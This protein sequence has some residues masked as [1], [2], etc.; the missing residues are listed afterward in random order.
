MNRY[1]LLLALLSAQAQ[2]LP[3]AQELAKRQAQFAPVEIGADIS[4][5]SDGDR[6][7]LAS[8]IKAA[9]VMD[10]LFLKQVW[11]AAPEWLLRLSADESMLG[12]ARLRYFL[13]QKGPWDRQDHNAAFIPDT[14]PKPAQANFYPTDATKEEVEAWIASLPEVEKAK[15]VG[16]FT[17]IRRSGPKFQTIPYAVEYQNDLLRAAAHLKD[18]AASTTNA[19]LKTFLN[20][21]A[22]AFL[23]DD[24]YDSDVAWMELDSPLE[25]TIGPYETYEDG[26]FSYKAAFEAFITL[27]DDA[28]TD[29]LKKFGAE[30]QWLE[31]NLPIDK[32][33]KN[34][35]LGALAPI[36]VVNEVYAAGDAARGVTT[37]AFNLPN[38]EKVTAEKGAKRT[39]LKNIQR[40][41]FDVVLAP[42]SK[43]SLSAADQP[44]V[45]FDSF[46]THILMHELMHGLG[47]HHAKDSAGKTIP[48]RQALKELSSSLEEAKADSAGLWALQKLVDKGVLDKR[49]EV[50][51]YTTFL[52]SAFR[53]LRFGVSESH[54]RGMALQLNYLLDKGAFVV[55]AD[56]TFS[57]DTAKVKGG[58]ESLAREIMTAQAKGDYAE[59][60]KWLET[61]AV[62]RP[63]AKAVIDKAA[64]LAVDI[65]PRFIT[66][67]ELGF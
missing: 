41:K 33:L 5:L 22:A 26:W 28:E 34:P 29:K 15:A 20:K 17:T 65:A 42:L 56:G 67:E 45:D 18:A 44:N 43:Y 2:A 9:Q 54:G 49:F 36:R 10:G 35:K 62:L 50:V 12:R 32:A 31:D 64:G 47:P 7:A 24:Y 21:R 16:F 51:M 66:A 39:M 4:K 27:R 11:D 40:A 58:V 3:N 1:L 63:E 53:T 48:V 59:T 25:P 14:P 46:F 8:L 55:A 13:A 61:M 60:K 38:D 52:A 57:V 19:S 30:L 23:N 37:A 6:T